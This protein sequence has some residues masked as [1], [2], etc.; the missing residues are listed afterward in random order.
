M[1][2]GFGE[3]KL[4]IITEAYPDILER[5]INIS[6]IV[7]LDGFSEK[8]ASVFIQHLPEFLKFLKK[9]TY[10]KFGKKEKESGNMT[11]EIVVFSGFR[12]KELEEKIRSRG[13]EVGGNITSK[14]TLLIV[15]D[16]KETSKTKKAK[17]LNIKVID[18]ETFKKNEIKDK[19]KKGEKVKEEEVEFLYEELENTMLRLM[20]NKDDNERTKIWKKIRSFRDYIELYNKQNTD[21]KKLTDVELKK[22][23]KNAKTLIICANRT[24]IEKDGTYVNKNIKGLKEFLQLDII[25]DGILTIDYKEGRVSENKR[26]LSDLDGKYPEQLMEKLKKFKMIK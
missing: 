8:T 24:D 10:F 6:D 2:T 17:E 4:A 5:K 9:N 16:D 15:K 18:L 26:N 13:G 3:K 21:K 12:D 23:I 20:D 25:K 22:V 19:L 1:E 11:G 14:T 7:K